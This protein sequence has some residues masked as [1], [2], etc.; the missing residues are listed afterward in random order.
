MSKQFIHTTGEVIA[1]QSFRQVS[2]SGAF[3]V[4]FSL[5]SLALSISGCS[6]DSGTV[7]QA[8]TPTAT[9]S[10]GAAVKNVQLTQNTPTEIKFT[11][12]IPGDIHSK[13]DYS[14]NLEKTLENIVLS[15]TPVASRGSHL[16]TLRLLAYALIKEAFAA[17][18]AEISAYISHA[19]D[20][21][22]CNSPYVFGPYSITG[23]IGQAL[24]STTGS[25][26]PSQAAVDIVNAGSFEICVKTTPP[27]TA[28]LTVTGVAM[29]I[30]DCAPPTVDIVGTWTGTF[31]CDNVGFPDTP[32]TDISLDITRNPDGSYHYTDGVA[33]YDGQ[34]CGNK[35]KFNGGAA[36]DYNES[37][38]LIV[39]GNSGTK[40]SN[41][42]DVV[43]PFSIYGRCVD[44]LTKS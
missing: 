1:M 31:T 41:W 3:K 18:T 25:V 39:T 20:P 7:L 43:S 32:L 11:Y 12:T 19:G 27:I 29:D 17:E 21:N 23:A 37:G 42:Q 10:L 34:L 6:S 30:E 5:C 13:G 14:V 9:A 35:F 2:I 26:T 44:D 22:V 15:A 36:G 8:T 38:S 40:T 16:E 28:F 24:T 33:D 4:L